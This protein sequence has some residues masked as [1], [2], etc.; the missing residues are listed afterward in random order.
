MKAIYKEVE[1]KDKDT[2]TIIPVGDMHVGSKCFDKEYFED[3]MDW[4]MK[5]ENCYVVGMGDAVDAVVH[6]DTRRFDIETIDPEFN[7]PE[8]QHR[9]VEYWY[10]KLYDAGKLLFILEGNHEAEI[11]KRYNVEHCNR[12]SYDIGVPYLGVHGM[13]RFVIKKKGKSKH[14]TTYDVYAHHGWAAGRK[15]GSVVNKCQDLAETY[16]ADLYLMGHSHHK[17]GDINCKIRLTNKKNDGSIDFVQKKVGFV[18]TGTFMRNFSPDGTPTYAERAG[19]PP[20][21]LG[22][23]KILLDLRGDI[24][25]RP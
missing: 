6:L 4:I 11:R 18:N 1:A 17:F 9:Y 19:Y 20:K 8:K 23:V 7:T 14:Q 2:I 5:E 22:V 10:K 24:H 12:W 21:Q 15:T 16:D 3:M 25:L 13:M